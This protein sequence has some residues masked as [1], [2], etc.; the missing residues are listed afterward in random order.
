MGF[1]F[2]FK[3]KT[4]FFFLSHYLH[5]MG[6]C[7][8]MCNYFCSSHAKCPHDGVGAILKRFNKSEFNGM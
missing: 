4:F 1:K 8:C 6:G 5:L 7:S 3:N 2:E